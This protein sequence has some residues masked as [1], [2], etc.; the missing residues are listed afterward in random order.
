VQEKTYY[1]VFLSYGE[2]QQ[3]TFDS[4]EEATPNICRPAFSSCTL[5]CFILSQKLVLSANHT[6]SFS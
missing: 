5:S 4:E 6:F 3:E 1:S 2:T